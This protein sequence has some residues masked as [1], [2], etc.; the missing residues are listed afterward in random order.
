M[1]LPLIGECD[2]AGI[3][4]RFCLSSPAAVLVVAHQ[5]ES[6]AGKLY[7]DLVASSGV[8]TDVDATALT[9]IQHPVCKPGLFDPSAL[10]FYHKDFIFAA[11]LK[12]QI[13][14]ITLLGRPAVDHSHVLLDHFSV[15]D[16]FGEP[17]GSLLCAG[18]DHYAAHV[19][20]QSVQGINL[21]AQ[22][23]SQTLGQIVFGIQPDRLDADNKGIAVIQDFQIVTPPSF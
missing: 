20:I 13:F 6:P 15:L 4:H 21:S 2:P 18:E 8:K 17:G 19:L 16:G 12:K 7:T 10:L 5:G 1:C 3:K 14:P 23:P 22:F 9:G 11:V